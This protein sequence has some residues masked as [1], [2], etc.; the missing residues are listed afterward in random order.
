MKVVRKIN[1]NYDSLEKSLRRVGVNVRWPPDC[2]EM[3]PETVERPPLEAVTK[4][5][6]EDRD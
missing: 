4:H 5:R 1:N 3:S 6:S 2:E